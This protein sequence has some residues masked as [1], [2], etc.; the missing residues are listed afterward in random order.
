M[1]LESVAVRP[2]IKTGDTIGENTQGTLAFVKSG[3]TA[4]P[5]L[6]GL[7]N[8]GIVSAV[9][10][11]AWTVGVNNFP[12]FPDSQP[13]TGIFYPA[14]QSISGQV[15]ANFPPVQ[16]IS[17]QV[18]ANFPATQSISGNTLTTVSNFPA[19]QSVTGNLAISGGLTDTQL[20]A[21][22]VP[23]SGTFYQV[24]QPVSLTHEARIQ[25]FPATQSI[26]GNTLVTLSNTLMSIAGNASIGIN[27][28]PAT[29]PVTGAFWQST[30]PVSITHEIRV[31][32][33]AATQSITGTTLAQVNQ[34]QPGTSPWP[35]SVAGNASI[36]V[37]NWPLTQSVTGNTLTTVS[38]ILRS[39]AGTALVAADSSWATAVKSGD[40]I[41]GSTEA[42]L[43]AVSAGTTVSWMGQPLT[44]TQLRASALPVSI[45]GGASIGL[46]N[47]PLT[48]SVSGNTLV[49]PSTL[50]RSISGNTLATISNWPVTQSIAGTTL[51]L[52]NQ[53]AAGA[54]PWPVSIAGNASIGINNWPV[55]SL[56]GTTLAMVNQGQAGTSRWLTSAAIADSLIPAIFADLRTTV[57][58]AKGAAGVLGGYIIH[59][60][61]ATEVY[62]QLFDTAGAVT[63]GS[64]TPWMFPGFPA[65]ATANVFLGNIPF[66]NGLKCAATTTPTGNT[67]PVGGLDVNLL[68]R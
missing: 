42:L 2:G 68:I 44:D 38:N 57:Q 9:Q 50:L 67:A 40:T 7:Q 35:V 20:R 16:S 8:G 62:L 15:W 31:Q 56:T 24:T 10:Q 27:N 3:T 28:W 5:L 11:G 53:G 36:G 17:G 26:T 46:N 32:N 33:F 55:Q 60:R 52:A 18:W 66:A 61:A 58:T 6:Q 45:A 51:T 21:Q 1:Y 30:Q 39:I 14:V 12:A 13:V 41:T 65:S 23:V 48:Q 25:N 4:T 29:Q 63:L 54:N 22:P 47:W 19:V 37:N 64:T 43:M 59:N 49:T 34:G